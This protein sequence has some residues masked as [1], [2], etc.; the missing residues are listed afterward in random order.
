M[1]KAVITAN[2][3]CI[4]YRQGKQEKRVHEHLPFSSIPEN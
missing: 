2:N 4:G 3:L 1:E